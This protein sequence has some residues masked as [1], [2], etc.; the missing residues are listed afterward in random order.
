MSDR[1]RGTTL[2]R[3]CSSSPGPL[4]GQGRAGSLCNFSARYFAQLFGP[5]LVSMV[6][7]PPTRMEGAPPQGRRRGACWCRG[8]WGQQPRR[9]GV[10]SPWSTDSRNCGVLLPAFFGPAQRRI[11]LCRA[12]VERPGSQLG[13][14]NR[15]LTSMRTYVRARVRFTLT[16]HDPERAWIVRGGQHCTVSLEDGVE[17]FAW[18]HEQWPAPRW[19]IELAPGQLAPAWPPFR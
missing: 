1:S 12:S 19:S 15:N 9:R 3:L 17:F 7:C 4:E 2:E 13:Q 6:G 16:E 18:A 10:P 11:D 5:T 8:L 14:A